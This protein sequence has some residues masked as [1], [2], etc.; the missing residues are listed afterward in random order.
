MGRLTFL[1]GTMSSGKT[2]HLLQTHFNVEDAFPGQVLLV[3]KND[4]SGDSVCSNRMGGMSISCGI[5][6]ETNLIDLVSD[7]EKKNEEKILYIFADEVQFF[8]EEQIEQ[9]AHLCDVNDMTI[10]AY[11]LLTSYKGE[12]FKA[13]KRLIELADRIVQIGNGMRCWCGAMATHNGL[14]LKGISASAGLDTVVDNES[15]VDY[16]VMCRKHFLEHIG[17]RSKSDLHL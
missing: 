16:R 15:T 5:D 1:V 10:N 4:R 13:T 12:L 6:D 3:N 9:M 17:F 8:S 7:T 2:T 14:Y 11:G